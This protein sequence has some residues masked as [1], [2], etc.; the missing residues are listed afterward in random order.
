MICSPYF[1]N[2]L[3]TQ[4]LG[5]SLASNSVR[6]LIADPICRGAQGQSCEN[7]D[8]L[9]R[10]ILQWNSNY[11][12]NWAH[13]TIYSRHWTP[14]SGAGG[15]APECPTLSK[16]VATC[17][18]LGENEL[19]LTMIP[20]VMAP[21]SPAT[22]QVINNRP[23][24]GAAKLCRANMPRSSPSPGKALPASCAP[25]SMVRSLHTLQLLLIICL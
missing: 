20:N 8:W 22:F 23:A 1:W 16:M 13:S 18:Y 4:T 15:Q 11:K 14:R 12:R 7:T 3:S 2:E 19:K 17:G 21:I 6:S 24:W 10:L 9:Q 25:G 5:I